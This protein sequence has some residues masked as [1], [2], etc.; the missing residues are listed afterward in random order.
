MEQI[1]D[2]PSGYIQ[3]ITIDN[4]R[5]Y[6]HGKQGTCHIQPQSAPEMSLS[7]TDASPGFDSNI[8][9]KSTY[10]HQSKRLEFVAHLESLGWKLLYIRTI[11][12]TKK[13]Q[14]TV[15]SVDGHVEVYKYHQ[16]DLEMKIRNRLKRKIYYYISRSWMLVHPRNQS[17]VRVCLTVDDSSSEPE[18]NWLIQ[19]IGWVD[20]DLLGTYMDYR[21]YESRLY[22]SRKYHL[23]KQPDIPLADAI[24]QIGE[25]LPSLPFTTL[26]PLNY[27]DDILVSS[28][29]LEPEIIELLATLKVPYKQCTQ[30]E[31]EFTTEILTKFQGKVSYEGGR[32]AYCQP[33]E[34]HTM[35]SAI[36][37]GPKEYEG[38]WGEKYCLLHSD[39]ISSMENLALQDARNDLKC[40]LENIL[41]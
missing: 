12:G 16:T 36:C 11:N 18:G 27:V 32:F 34:R 6:I 2:S 1:Y 30:S 35:W 38:P 15:E 7:Y 8:E 28:D 37:T 26:S 22:E 40:Y 10:L 3:T 20:L 14:G 39:G 13:I 41:C 33:G 21:P 9:W 29:K 19:P 17:M 5:I 25:K 4:D 31:H 24:H 23:S